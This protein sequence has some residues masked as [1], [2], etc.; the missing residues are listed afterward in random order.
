MPY[1][2]ILDELVRSVPGAVG[3][4]LLDSEGEVVVQAGA[5]DYRHKLI[6][7]YQGIALAVARRIGGRHG[8]GA[9]NG[10][11][12]R[13]TEAALVLRPL[14]DGYFFVL[15]LAPGSVVAEA[16]RLADGVRGRMNEAL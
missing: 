5:R 2:K 16:E 13:Y 14:K 3:A 10:L 6:G 11:T 7:A 9:V 1:Q 12:C 4:L 8:T 15:S